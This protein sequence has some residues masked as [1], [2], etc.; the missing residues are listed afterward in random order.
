MLHIWDD[1]PN[2]SGLRVDGTTSITELNLFTPGD[3]GARIIP[4]QV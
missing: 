4:P 2:R 3:P 1:I